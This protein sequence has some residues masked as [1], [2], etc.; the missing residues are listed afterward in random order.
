MASGQFG[1]SVDVRG[2]CRRLLVHR[3]SGGMAVWLRLRVCEGWRRVVCV[4][5]SVLGL[6]DGRIHDLEVRYDIRLYREVLQSSV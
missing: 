6:Y 1:D 3:G 4:S 5:V 2:G